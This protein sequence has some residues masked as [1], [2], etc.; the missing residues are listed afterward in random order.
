MEKKKINLITMRFLKDQD[1]R[2]FLIKFPYW[3]GIGADALWAVALFF[4]SV[5]GNLTGNQEFIP[6]FQTRQ[7]LSIAGTLM[8]GWTLLLL[9]AVRNPIERRGVILLTAVPVVSGLL[10]VGLFGL[11]NGSTLPVWIIVKSIIL[12]ISMITSFIL[13]GKQ[14]ENQL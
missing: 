10:I 4:P 8:T 12:I 9:W 13:S 3:L 1:K 7:I 14:K 11:L 5:Y 2:M 6:E